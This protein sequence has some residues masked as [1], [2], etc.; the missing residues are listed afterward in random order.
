MQTGDIVNG[1]IT[2][3]KPYGAF[4]KI[5]ENTTGLIHISELSNQ[6]VRDVEDFVEVGDTIDLKVIDVADDGKISLSYKAL[7]KKKKRYNI[8]LESGFKPLK[9]M[10]ETWLENAQK[11]SE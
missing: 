7:H 3:I 4:V 8:E 6:F 1:E 2:A 5:D 9:E 10:L 11:D